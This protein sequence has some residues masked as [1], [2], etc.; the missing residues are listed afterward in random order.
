VPLEIASRL[1]CFF[2]SSDATGD[3]ISVRFW[4]RLAG[5]LIIEH[6]GEGSGFTAENLAYRE[7]SVAIVVLTNQDAASPAGAIA[8]AISEILF[9]SE[10]KL[11]DGRVEQAKAIF[12]GLQ[13][14]TI[15]RSLLTPNAN[16]YFSEQALKDFKA[17]LAP[18]GAPIG[19]VQTRTTLRGGMTYRNYRV[20]LPI[21][22]CGC[23]HSR[24]QKGSSNSIRSLLPADPT[25]TSSVRGMLVVCS[26]GESRGGY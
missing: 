18:L 7:D 20:T 25:S 15:D 26:N 12:A 24:R 22:P 14:G 23:G 19:F 8:N 4:Y 3:S 2:N 9:T 13:R 6:G 11:A 5:G 10:D 17:S 1:I 21:V 16:F